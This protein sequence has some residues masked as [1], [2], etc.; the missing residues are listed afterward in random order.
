MVCAGAVVFAVF[1]V[2]CCGLFAFGLF[3]GL[4]NVLRLCV[5]ICCAYVG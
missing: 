3:C 2:F 4:V 1:L 5:L